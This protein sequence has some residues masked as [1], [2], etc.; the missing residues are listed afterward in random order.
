MSK[1]KS[2][3]SAKLAGCKVILFS[4]KIN[5]E[6]YC[7]IHVPG[8]LTTTSQIFPSKYHDF[9]VASF[10]LEREKD[11]LNISLDSELM[12]SYALQIT[13][14]R[15]DSDLFMKRRIKP[16]LA[17]TKISRLFLC[18]GMASEFKFSG[19]KTPKAV[20]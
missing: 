8:L 10:H 2:I 1:V 6:A 19:Q 16:N 7:G 20:G 13:A 11:I 3:L 5:L 4:Q 9:L 17:D 12:E 15:E 14:V 18:T